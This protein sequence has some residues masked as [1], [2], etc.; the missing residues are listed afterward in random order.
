MEPLVSRYVVFLLSVFL[1]VNF[2][3]YRQGPFNPIR[4]LS[5]VT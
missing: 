1:K 3:L 2:L 4:K 5:K